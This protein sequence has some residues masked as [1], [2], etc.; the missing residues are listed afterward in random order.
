[1]LF[2]LIRKKLFI[3]TSLVERQLYL[4]IGG[5]NP[6][7]VK[8]FSQYYNTDL[9]N[10]LHI[11]YLVFYSLLTIALIPFVQKLVKLRLTE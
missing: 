9:R 5:H 2:V 1:M 4:V 7:T 10:F 3:E 8:I 11:S 6:R